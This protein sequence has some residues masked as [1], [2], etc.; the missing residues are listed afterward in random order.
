MV[1]DSFSVSLRTSWFV[2]IERK[3]RRIDLQPARTGDLHNS[4]TAMSCKALLP[5]IVKAQRYFCGSRR[6]IIVTISIGALN[7]KKALNN[8]SD[9]SSESKFPVEF[10]FSMF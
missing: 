10:F 5:E 2:V 9:A 8:V 7:K 4:M 1:R 6:I 3:N